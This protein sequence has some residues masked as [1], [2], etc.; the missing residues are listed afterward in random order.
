MNTETPGPASRRKRGRPPACYVPRVRLEP[1]LIE[2]Q[3]VSDTNKAQGVVA[4]AM[5]GGAGLSP[6][7]RFRYWP[8]TALGPSSGKGRGEHVGHLSAL[9]WCKLNDEMEG[10]FNARRAFRCRDRIPNHSSTWT[11]PLRGGL[12]VR[13]LLAGG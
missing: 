3:G 9:G 11:K 5:P 2:I 6:D 7:G 10:R 4:L 8:E 12:G 13:R 1:C